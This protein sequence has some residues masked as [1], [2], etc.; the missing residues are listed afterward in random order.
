MSGWRCCCWCFLFF[1][2]ALILSIRSHGRSQEAYFFLYRRWRFLPLHYLLSEHI[3]TILVD[4]H[5]HHCLC[6]SS[7]RDHYLLLFFP[8]RHHQLWFSSSSRNCCLSLAVAVPVSRCCCWCWCR[9][10]CSSFPFSATPINT[11]KRSPYHQFSLSSSRN[12]L[13][14]LSEQK[15]SSLVKFCSNHHLRHL[16]FCCCLS[17]NPRLLLPVKCSVKTSSLSSPVSLQLM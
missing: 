17:R 5:H 16:G 14:L 10:C 4:Q 9:S 3:I 11:N 2:A 12:C 13:V 6:C 7:C 1:P 15:A 8:I